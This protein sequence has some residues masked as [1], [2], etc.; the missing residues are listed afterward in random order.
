MPFEHEKYI[1][2]AGV[3][4][5][6]DVDRTILNTDTVFDIIVDA[7][8]QGGVDSKV[9]ESVAARG[10]QAKEQAFD[11][12]TAISKLAPGIHIE[13]AVIVDR[14]GSEYDAESLI[15][16]V[17]A[18]GAVDMIRALKDVGAYTL[19]LTAGGEATQK[20][21]LLLLE[22]VF[23]KLA[24]PI[25]LPPWAII[26]SSKQY[27]TQLAEEAYN[28]ELKIFSLDTLLS[29]ALDSNCIES[30]VTGAEQVL[31]VDDKLCN[32]TSVG[33]SRITGIL[34]QPAELATDTTDGE[35]RKTLKEVSAFLRGSP[36]A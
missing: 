20:T 8:R 9:L 13:P 22:T 2:S 18:P 15:E 25:Q 7:L 24:R 16:K 31:V 5:L 36:K 32:V 4:A 3:V 11:Y 17:I 26:D 19:L 28:E 14:I 33:T 1:T 12:L 10:K 35:Q 21:K 6:I 27:K 30:S 23:S 29:H 34:V